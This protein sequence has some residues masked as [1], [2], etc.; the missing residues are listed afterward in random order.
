MTRVQ[1]MT[2]GLQDEPLT[3]CPEFSSVL[4]GCDALLER[5]VAMCWQLP[6]SCERSAGAGIERQVRDSASISG[7]ELS[8]RY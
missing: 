5:A 4:C 7:C 3:D 2:T 1:M 8:A 6:L